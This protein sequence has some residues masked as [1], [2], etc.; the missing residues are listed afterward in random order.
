[1]RSE[2]VTQRGSPPVRTPRR[3]SLSWAALL[4]SATLGINV[5]SDPFALVHAN[6]RRSRPRVKC[7]RAA[8]GCVRVNYTHSVC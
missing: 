2:G 1:M 4:R 7:Q 8:A 6:M 3:P 5:F